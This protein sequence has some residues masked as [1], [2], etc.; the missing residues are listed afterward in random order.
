[1][2]A[3]DEGGGVEVASAGMDALALAKKTAM[4]TLLK[5]VEFL[6][7]RE[8]GEEKKEEGKR[9]RK[10]KKKKRKGGGVRE[11]EEE[12][13]VEDEVVVKV[14]ED[15]LKE[16]NVKEEV[17]I[18]YV[19]PED[20]ALDGSVLGEGLEAFQDV[21]QRFQTRGIDG[22]SYAEDAGVVTGNR[23]GQEEGDDA[24]KKEQNKDEN[25]E[26]KND[27]ESEEKKLSRRQRKMHE[28]MSVARLKQEVRRE[29]QTVVES[30][31][32]D[33]AGHPQPVLKM[34]HKHGQWFTASTPIIA[35]G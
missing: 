6:E 30:K 16:E 17:E 23:E 27:E 4:E 14:K 18:E 33:E 24:V 19:P 10:K 31:L 35:V 34:L 15:D 22:S 8:G 3:E 32:Q 20:I 11:E 21:F 29:K 26:D 28:R 12:V 7:D 5:S 2:A 1:M 9:K 13:K 25:D